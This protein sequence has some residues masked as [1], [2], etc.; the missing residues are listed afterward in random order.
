MKNS[1]VKAF[2]LIEIVLAMMLAGIMLGMAYTALR[3]FAKIYRDYHGKNIANAGIRVFSGMINDDLANAS[4]ISLAD[5]QINFSAVSDSMGLRYLLQSDHVI[6]RKAGVQDTFRMTNLISQASFEGIQV[7]SGVVDQLVFKF[8]FEGSPML[9]S[10]TKEYAAA[11]LF[12]HTDT[13]WKQ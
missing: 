10:V 2:T 7:S 4:V 6:R 3:L 1:K 8:D 11:D 13:I 9:I 5:N 12:N